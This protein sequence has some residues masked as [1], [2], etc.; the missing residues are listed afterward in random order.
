[1]KKIEAS[2]RKIIESLLYPES[3]DTILEE[4]ELHRGEIRDDLMQMLNSGFIK[5]MVEGKEH[6]NNI[7]SFFDSDNLEDY[8]FQ[9]TK[10]VLK[11]L[12]VAKT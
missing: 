8:T 4:T 2:K 1:M 6:H 5:A 12:M 7:T 9:A 3:F 11:A 10:R